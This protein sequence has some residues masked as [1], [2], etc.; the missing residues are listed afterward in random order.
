MIENVKLGPSP[1]WLCD[2]LLAIGLRP[3]NNIVDITNFVM[4]EYGQPLHAFDRELL[5]GNQIIIRSAK[6]GEKFTS[7]DGSELKLEPDTLV[8]ADAEKPVA[9]GPPTR[10]RP[11]RLR[12]EDDLREDPE[13]HDAASSR[14]LERGDRGSGGST[15]NRRG[16]R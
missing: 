13:F 7:L 8:I 14:R 15:G 10:R 6:K 9:L 12:I 1:K 3:I 11:S 2:H 16:Y 5:S 4:M